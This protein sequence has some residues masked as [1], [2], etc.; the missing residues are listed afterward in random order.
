MSSGAVATSVLHVVQIET[1]LGDPIG[2]S[3]FQAAARVRLIKF[4]KAAALVIQI[5]KATDS[6]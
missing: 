2:A 1:E 3:A 6:G 5:A 4:D